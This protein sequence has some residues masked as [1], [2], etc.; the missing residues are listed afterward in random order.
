[1]KLSVVLKGIL[2]Y[3]P[4]L[5]FSFYLF[6]AITAHNKDLGF[7]SIQDMQ[8]YKLGGAQAN[9]VRCHVSIDPNFIHH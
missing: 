4:N 7:I 2:V 6:E 1:M 5:D 3:D 9:D 8:S